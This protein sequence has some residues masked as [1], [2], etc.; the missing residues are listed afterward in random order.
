[1][2]VPP[3]TWVLVVGL[4]AAVVVAIP[5][6]WIRLKDARRAEEAAKLAATTTLRTT[7]I[8]VKEAHCRD[9]AEQLK[10]AETA[11]LVAA[12]RRLLDAGKERRAGL[13]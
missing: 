12:A 1:M 5:W 11:E 2:A 3:W 10:N 7:K 13:R 6:M 8:A 9:A 4:G